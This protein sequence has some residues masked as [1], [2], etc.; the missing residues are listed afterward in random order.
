MLLYFLCFFFFLSF[1]VLLLFV[2]LVLLLLLLLSYPPLS[3]PSTTLLIL[4][5][6][7]LTGTA[8]LPCNINNK[9]LIL[10]ISFK[11]SQV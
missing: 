3:L 5:M 2:D 9:P 7:R 11:Q 4:S 1:F 10:D 8:L 6:G